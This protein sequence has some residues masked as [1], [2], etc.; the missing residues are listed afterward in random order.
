ML[1]DRGAPM[2]IMVVLELTMVGLGGY[3]VGEYGI[4]GRGCRQGSDNPNPIGQGIKISVIY[5]NLK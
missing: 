2:V 5:G 3:L 4:Y 1:G